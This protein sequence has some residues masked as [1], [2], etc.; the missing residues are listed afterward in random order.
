L[1]DTITDEHRRTG[2]RT[3]RIAPLLELGGFKYL[4]S[5]R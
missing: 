1:I 5:L 2:Q 4:R 3:H